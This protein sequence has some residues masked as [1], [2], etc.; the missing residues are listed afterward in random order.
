MP[1]S[2]Q[3]T[4]TLGASNKSESHYRSLQRPWHIVLFRNS[5]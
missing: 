2:Q 5:A 3:Q 4:P 1:P